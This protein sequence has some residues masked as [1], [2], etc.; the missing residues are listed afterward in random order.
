MKKT[1]L[2]SILCLSGVLTGFSQ[3]LI[4]S[5]KVTSVRQ[6]VV[7]DTYRANDNRALKVKNKLRDP[8]KVN[9][10]Y[11][12]T[13]GKNTVMKVV[14]DSYGRIYK[15]YDKDGKPGNRLM[16]RRV[17]KNDNEGVTSFKEDFES[18]M[19]EYGLDW[20]PDGWTELNSEGNIPTQEMLNANINNTWYVNWTGDGYWIPATADGE[21]DAFIH[22]TYNSSPGAKVEVVASPQDELL[23]TPNIT[24]KQGDK[25]FFDACIDL[26]SVYKYDWYSGLYDREEVECDLEVLASD[27]DGANWKRIWSAAAD[28]ASKMSNNDLY[29]AMELIYYSYSVSVSDYVGKTIKLAFR[30]INTSDK[31][32]SLKGNSMSLDAV[33]VGKTMPVAGYALPYGTLLSGLSEDLYIRPEA[34]AVMPAYTPLNWTNTSNAHSTSFE[35]TFDGIKDD[36]T[37]IVYDDKN[38]I[39]SWPYTTALPPLLTAFNENGKNSYRWGSDDMYEARMQFGGTVADNDGT[40]YGLGNYDYVHKDIYT[41]YFSG[42]NSYCFGTGSDEDWGAKIVGVGNLF[43]KPAAPLYVNKMYL[44][45]EVLDADPDAELQLDVYSVD[46]YGVTGTLAHGKAK[47]SDAYS[48][49]GFIT[50]P[51]K[52]YTEDSDGNEVET[53]FMLTEDALFEVSGFADNDKVRS[54]AAM[55]Q[56]ENHDNKKNYVYANFRFSSG[57]EVR[58][59]ASEVLDSYY[60]SLVMN[61]DAAFS[62]IHAENENVVIPGDGGA[63]IVNV[64][65]YYS[66]SEW[67]ID[68][69][70]KDYSLAQPLQLD[71]LTVEASYDETAKTAQIKFSADKTSVSHDETF[72]IEVK[73][74]SQVLTIS[75]TPT[76]G[77]SSLE[78]MKSS[79]KVENDVLNISGMENSIGKLVFLFGVEGRLVGKGIVGNDGCAE[80]NMNTLPKG[81]YVAKIGNMTFKFPKL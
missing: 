63:E 80:I 46:K 17:K 1:L 55:A 19:P 40:V 60:S 72:A 29:E 75:Q 31:D 44:T 8:Q 34:V 11:S 64:V 22:F 59:E 38:P 32:N 36:D 37:N 53:G 41:P 4:K 13:C 6:S 48:E 7:S 45:L 2:F 74:A 3:T 26:G 33:V 27:N 12:K 68:Y 69:A 70:G 66:P 52:F 5:E 71:W 49:I 56:S 51:F 73:G 50:L 81:V 79:V 54:F 20:I 10:L 30:Y 39:V 47:V 18:W 76:T 25:L 43:E 42:T 23:I 67:N 15:V 14:E 58:W 65:S 77:M 24:V 57:S 35:W 9:V 21:K 16:P 78:N 62:F 61:L 28:V